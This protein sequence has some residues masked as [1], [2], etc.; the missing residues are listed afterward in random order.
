[1]TDLREITERLADALSI[2]ADA[3][4]DESDADWAQYEIDE[5]VVAGR[6]ALADLAQC[7]RQVFRNMH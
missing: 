4:D 7:I 3:A 1:M 2:L 6:H 5:A